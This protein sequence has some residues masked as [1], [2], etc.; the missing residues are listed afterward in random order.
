MRLEFTWIP[1]KFLPFHSDP[2]GSAWIR[3]ECPGQGKV[4]TVWYHRRK[5]WRNDYWHGQQYTWLS[6]IW[7]GTV[8]VSPSSRNVGKGLGS[9]VKPKRYFQLDHEWYQVTP[10]TMRDV[11]DASLSTP[12]IIE[13]PDSRFLEL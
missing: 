10:P 13:P 6:G 9:P 11:D 3:V 7:V 1:T 12:S 5:I 8:G 2:P 4:L